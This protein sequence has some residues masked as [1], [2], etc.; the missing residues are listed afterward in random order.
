M[1]SSLAS[2]ETYVSEGNFAARK[3]KMFSPEVKNIFLYR[4]QF[5]LPKHVSQFSHDENNVD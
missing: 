1:F 4:T 3:Q 2:R 5:L